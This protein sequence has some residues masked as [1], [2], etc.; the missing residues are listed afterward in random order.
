MNH[1]KA[2]TSM[3]AQHAGRAVDFDGM[4]IQRFAIQDETPA[5]LELHYEGAQVRVHLDGAH[6]GTLDGWRGMKEGWSTTLD[7]GSTLEVRTI[8]RALF[9]E[10]SILRNGQHVASSPSHPEKML[11][12]TVTAMFILS[13]IVIVRGARSFGAG[14]WLDVLFGVFY[15]AGALLLRKR[16]RLGALFISVP[17]FIGLDLL[18]LAAFVGEVDRQWGISLVANLIFVFFVTRAYQAARDSRALIEG[19]VR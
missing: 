19:P 15:V 2:G 6:V 16:R 8:R 9:P 17:L 18:L 4:R 5:R 7:D 13:A 12:S 11:R 14:G 1:A 10:L 3:H